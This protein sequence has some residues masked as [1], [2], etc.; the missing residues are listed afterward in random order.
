MGA[1]AIIPCSTSEITT[2]NRS[3]PF[4]EWRTPTIVG[5]G[6]EGSAGKRWSDRLIRNLPLPASATYSCVAVGE[7]RISGT[8]R[9]GAHWLALVLSIPLVFFVPAPAQAVIELRHAHGLGYSPDGGRILIP[10]HYGIAVY[11]EGRW[12]RVAGPALDYMG[13]VVTREFIFSSGHAAGSRAAAN[14]LGLMRSGDGGLSWT[15]LGLKGEGEFH[16]VAAGYLSN[17]VYVYNAEPNSVMPR[18]GLYRMMGDRLVGWRGAAGRGLQGEPGMLAAHPTQSAML[19]AATTAGLFLSRNGGEEFEPVMTAS[20]AT[21]A[22]FTLEGDALLVGTLEGR[23]AG[24]FRIGIKDGLR[25]ELA[26]PPF[27]RDAVANIAQ[28]PVRRAELAL[29][30]F[31]RAVFV[32][33]DAGMTWRRI[34]RAR[35][36]L[37]GRN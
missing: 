3:Q 33:S 28:N 1:A 6:H 13:F 32:S 15:T 34:A 37:P 22:R 4:S 8:R 9:I 16:L 29:I 5:Q 20:R 25:K 11:S 18:A 24:L 31:E 30:S 12:S 2:K 23:K 7:R 17:A 26:P 21:A 27:G 19:A 36:T 10:N 14:P 35:G